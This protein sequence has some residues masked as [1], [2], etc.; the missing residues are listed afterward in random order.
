MQLGDLYDLYSYSRFARSQNL[1]TPQ[2]EMAFGRAKAEDFWAALQKA[3]P[4]AECWQVIGNHDS[5]PFKRISELA[6]EFEHIVAK[7]LEGFWH[8]PGVQTQPSEKNELILD[9][10]CFMH[11][12]RQHGTHVTYNLMPTVVGH[13]HVGGVVYHR[14]KGRT[15]WELNCGFI[16]DRTSIPMSYTQQSKISRLTE[17]VG[18]I[19]DYGPRFIPL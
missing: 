18:F 7:G 2:K 5:R 10:I 14:I 9:G 1:T 6:P 19:D 12:Y 11:G 13:T 16:A 15:I 4:G 3:S 8:F 17:G